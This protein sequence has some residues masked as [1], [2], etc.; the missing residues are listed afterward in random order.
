MPIEEKLLDLMPIRIEIVTDKYELNEFKSY[1]QQY[2]YLGYDVNAGENIKYFVYDKDG[3]KLACLMFGAA[4][5][6]CQPRDDFIGWDS[7]KRVAGLK[8]ITNNSR[9]LVFPW[10]KCLHLASHI[11]G[12][13]SRRISSDW[14]NKYGHPLFC[15]ETFVEIDRF[16]GICYKASNWVCV[17]KTTGRGRNSTT[18]KGTLPIKDIYVYPLDKKFREKMRK[19]NH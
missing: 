16:K 3:H 7:E 4:A 17:G 11:L 14:M 1:I 9:F 10:V 15:L 8:Y 18:F 2:H 13:V 6:A 12:L 19:E 5:W